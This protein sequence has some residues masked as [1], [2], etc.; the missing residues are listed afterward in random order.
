MNDSQPSIERPARRI[1]RPRRATA[2]WILT[3]A[4]VSMLAA[5][6]WLAAEPVPANDD[7]KTLAP[8]AAAPSAPAAP[9]APVPP[10]QTLPRMPA[11]PAGPRRGDKDASGRL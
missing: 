8:G 9:A 7:P 4:L 1:R 6:G 2:P 11:P 3:A 5:L 10:A